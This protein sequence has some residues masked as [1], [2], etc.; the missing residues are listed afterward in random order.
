[1]VKVMT[2][3]FSILVVDD[4]PNNF[5]VIEALLSE[6]KYDLHYVA[7]GKR[8]IA[9]LEA[10][11][12]DAQ[13]GKLTKLPKEIAILFIAVRLSICDFFIENKTNNLMRNHLYP[14]SIEWIMSLYFRQNK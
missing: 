12:P 13:A 5:D 9:S 7:N 4:E 10:F 14:L 8:A 1:M 11:Q 6:Q 3:I 2:N